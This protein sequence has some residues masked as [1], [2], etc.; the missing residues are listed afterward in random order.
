MGLVVAQQRRVTV[1]VEQMPL[2]P[3][4]TEAMQRLD[5]LIHG[6]EEHTDPRVQHDLL[7]VLRAVDVLHRGALLR[8]AEL[9]ERRG[10]LDEALADG[11]IAMLLDLYAPH[12]EHETEQFRVQAV[13]EDLRPY[14]EA[15]G[16]QLEVLTAEDGALQVRLLAGCESRSESSAALRAHVEAA[17]RAALPDFAGRDATAPRHPAPAE[18]KAPVLI[19]LSALNQPAGTQHSSGGCGSGGCGS[20]G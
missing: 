8:L 14:V 18:R 12:D 5:D 6:L 10:L 4:V 19:P 7:E 17:L 16:G 2:S 13:V 3:E 9:L 20:S 1:T 11:H 15:H